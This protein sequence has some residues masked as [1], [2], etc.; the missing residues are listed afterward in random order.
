MA[1]IQP[2]QPPDLRR[3]IGPFFGDIEMIEDL[4]MKALERKG[5]KWFRITREGRMSM[6]EAWKGQY[7]PDNPPDVPELQGKLPEGWRPGK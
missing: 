2:V 5:Y 7:P 4:H 6:I 1:Q 3:Q